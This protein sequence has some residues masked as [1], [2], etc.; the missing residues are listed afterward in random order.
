[1]SI[2]DLDD[3]VSSQDDR[4]YQLLLAAIPDIMLRLNRAGVCLDFHVPQ[5]VTFRLFGAGIDWRGKFLWEIL[6]PHV[7]AQR[8]VYVERAIATNEVQV[9][10]Q[11]LEVCVLWSCVVGYHEMS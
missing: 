7:A 2:N 9:Y 6:P 1:M 3:I 5:L 8:M 4:N 11:E 10:E